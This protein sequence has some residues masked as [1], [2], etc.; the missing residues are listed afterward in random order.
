MLLCQQLQQATPQELDLAM[1]S[2][3]KLVRSEQSEFIEAEMYLRYESACLKLF[4]REG[5]Q[6]TSTFVNFADAKLN[7]RIRD[8][9]KTQNIAKAVGLKS[10]STPRVLDATTGMG[11]D[12]YLLASMGC[13]LDMLERSAVIYRLLQDGFRRGESAVEEVRE[14]LSRMHLSCAD[15]FDLD[16]HQVRKAQKYDVVY[17]DPMFP[18]RGKNGKGAKVKKEIFA[19]QKLLGHDDESLDWLGRARELAGKR[20]V[21]KRAKLSSFLNGE[22]PDIQFKGSSSR[23]DVYMMI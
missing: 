7:Y 20:I 4:L 2:N 3:I 18:V 19:L 16:I 8:K 13:Q 11:K 5:K 1:D 6:E 21:V 14:C 17:L 15:F 22:K 23:Y 10:I 12:A 9:G